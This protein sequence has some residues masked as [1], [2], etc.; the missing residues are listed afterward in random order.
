MKIVKYQTCIECDERFKQEDLKPL[1][2]MQG[3]I[4][5]AVCKECKKQ[6]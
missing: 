1:M 3:Y 4:E 6:L 5:H 2:T